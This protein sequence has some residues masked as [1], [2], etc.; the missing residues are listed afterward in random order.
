MVAAIG[1][2]VGFYVITRCADFILK[3]NVQKFVQVLAVITILVTVLCLFSLYTASST[4]DS[5]GNV[6]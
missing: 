5:V 6:P 4:M 3:E 1:Y 2:I